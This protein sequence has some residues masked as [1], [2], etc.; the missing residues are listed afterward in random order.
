MEWKEVRLGDICSVSRGASPRPIQAFLS[1]SGMPWVKISDATSINS[2]FIE[3]TSEYIIKE[4]IQKSRVVFPGDLIVSN[5]ATPG[6]PKYMAIEA[7]VHDGWLIIRDFQNVLKEFLYYVFINIRRELSNQANGSV[8]MNLKTEIVKN[9]KVLLPSIKEQQ[10]IADILS[11]L[12]AKIE[13]NNKINAK[14]EEMTQ[15][16]FKSWFID[17][18]PFKDGTFVESELGM[19]PEGWK[20][21]ALGDCTRLITKG[22]TPTSLKKEFKESG[23]VFVKAESIKDDHSLDFQKV[24]FI[25]EETNILLKRSIIC[26]NDI[27]FTIAGTLGRFCLVESELS[28]ANTNQAVAII[29]L[30]EDCLPSKVFFSY[31]LGN[32]H[33]DYCIRNIQQ[34]VQANLSLKTISCMPILVPDSETLRK[35]TC[36][37]EPIISKMKELEIENRNLAQT[38]DTLL[39]KLMSGEIEL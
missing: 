36:V 7:C 39:P 11:S 6:L 15:A 5:S 16:L 35:Y 4:G 2:R 22:T 19:I 28:V 25:D 21:K 24:S 1:E 34:A 33:K 29:R 38:R 17:F 18:E 31:L 27:L 9:Y 20:V 12:D 10:R 3:K 14:L 8:F 37:I 32:W 26:P 13:N 23:I 30:N